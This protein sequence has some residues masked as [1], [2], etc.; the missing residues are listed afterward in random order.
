MKMQPKNVA[1][2]RTLAPL[3]A[4]SRIG[5]PLVLMIKNCS[6]QP[7]WRRGMA[8]KRWQI[9]LERLDRDDEISI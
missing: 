5:Q 6:Q 1:E 8:I 4:R 7:I 2:R 9:S 3:G